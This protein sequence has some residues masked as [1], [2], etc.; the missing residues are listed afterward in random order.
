MK[1]YGL[2]ISIFTVFILIV[3][4]DKGFA[5][6]VGDQ[7]MTCGGQYTVYGAQ[8]FFF[9]YTDEKGN[10]GVQSF[11]ANSPGEAYSCAKKVCNECKLQDLTGLY[12][13]GSAQPG[14]NP[15]GQFCPKE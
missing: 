4:V 10:C 9:G 3:G 11:Y 7:T 12:Q 15:G 6:S 14:Y 2:L 1:A 5:L 13:F 8:N